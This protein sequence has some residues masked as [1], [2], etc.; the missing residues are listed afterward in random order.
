MVWQNY[1]GV[2]HCSAW[3]QGAW[4]SKYQRLWRL[5]AC[6]LNF[7]THRKG[8]SWREKTC[9]KQKHFI[10]KS[11]ILQVGRSGKTVTK[12]KPQIL[13]TRWIAAEHKS[14]AAQFTSESSIASFSICKW[15]FT[16]CTADSCAVIAWSVIRA[17][18]LRAPS[19]VA[20]R[21]GKNTGINWRLITAVPHYISNVALQFSVAHRSWSVGKQFLS[22]LQ[23]VWEN[24]RYGFTWD[25]LLLLFVL[26]GKTSRNFVWWSFF[27]SMGALVFF[28]YKSREIV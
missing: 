15:A 11:Y 9:Q 21:A 16:A 7:S 10:I 28:I 13:T 8:M 27:Y 22:P 25:L 23:C 19:N 17:V 12:M 3:Q 26:L 4:E 18:E 1:L 2:S 20:A 6:W 14:P 5:S 24:S